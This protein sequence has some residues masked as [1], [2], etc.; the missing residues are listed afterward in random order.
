MQKNSASEGSPS[1]GDVSA[2]SSHEERLI[3]DGNAIDMNKVST[4]DASGSSEDSESGLDSHISLSC[5]EDSNH[6]V[7]EVEIEET[8]GQK[9]V[10]AGSAVTRSTFE[11]LLLAVGKK[12][13]FSKF[14][15]EMF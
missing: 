12:H 4:D 2:E 5:T 7:D 15:R 3:A 10:C 13:K 11:A 9:P 6:E 14:T 1:S 8:D